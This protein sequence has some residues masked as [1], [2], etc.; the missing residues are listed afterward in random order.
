MSFNVVP[1]AKNNFF[2]FFLS[3]PEDVSEPKIW[4]YVNVVIVLRS[5]RMY[6]NVVIVLCSKRPC[7]RYYVEI[8]LI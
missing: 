5:K 6:V 7:P 1:Y 4:M 3:Y 2:M 8:G